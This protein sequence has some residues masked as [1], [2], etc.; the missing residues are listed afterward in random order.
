M[1][2]KFNHK[3]LPEGQMVKRIEHEDKGG[4]SPP[5]ERIPRVYEVTVDNCPFTKIKIRRILMIGMAKV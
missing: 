4:I 2:G 3:V 5:S 1:L